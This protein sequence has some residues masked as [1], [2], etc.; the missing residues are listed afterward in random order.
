MRTTAQILEAINAEHG[1]G[2]SLPGLLCA[3]C[4]AFMDLSGSGM[5]LINESGHQ[6]VIGA[7]GPL[8][9]QLEDLQF[10]LGE[11]PSLDA[12]RSNSPVVHPDL[13]AAAVLPWLGFGPAAVA[14]G[15]RAVFALPLQVGTTPLG[16]L[17]LYRATP[18]RWDDEGTATAMAYADAAVEVLL[19]LQAQTE[20]GSALH[21]ELDEPVTYRAEVH[22]ATGYLSVQASV[23]LAEALLL[24]RAHAFASDRPLLQI[25]RDVLAGRLRIQPEEG[26]D[27]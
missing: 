25:A 12:S 13:S 16:A 6:G 10:E 18:G 5:A 7:S 26:E 14:A 20:P 1:S 24:L 23:G 22:Q 19:L 8:A 21:P 17:C 11:G 3:D 2:D 4:S 15:V 9:A 27:D